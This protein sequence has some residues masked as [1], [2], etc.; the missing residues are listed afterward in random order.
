MLIGKIRR[1]TDM[2]ADR[3]TG[4]QADNQTG[5]QADKQTGRQ[6]HRHTS[7]QAHRQTSRHADRHTGTHVDRQVD[8]PTDRQ[9]QTDKLYKTTL[10]N[11]FQ[12][13]VVLNIIERALL[14][15]LSFFKFWLLK[16]KVGFGSFFEFDI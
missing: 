1:A 16:E 8:E 13:V 3:Q 11:K 15:R 9:T 5:R 12:L 7:T 14:K 2:Q 10:P 6:A 4:R